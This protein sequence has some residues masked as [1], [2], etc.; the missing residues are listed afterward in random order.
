LRVVSIL[1]TCAEMCCGRAKLCKRGTIGLTVT[2]GVLQVE[3]ACQKEW[4]AAVP[5]H[6]P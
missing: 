2:N 6:E 1:L 5:H 4:F 3:K